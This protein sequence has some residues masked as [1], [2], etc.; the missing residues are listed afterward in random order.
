[1]D[2]RNQ[3]ERQLRSKIT[4]LPK[5]S[6]LIRKVNMNIQ[7]H[8]EKQKHQKTVSQTD[9]F[10]LSKTAAL[11]CL[12][13]Y[14]QAQIIF[15]GQSKAEKLKW[16][17]LNAEQ[18][19][20][21]P[22][23]LFAVILESLPFNGC[24]LDFDPKSKAHPDG[25]DPKILKQTWVEWE[26]DKYPW[27]QDSPHGKHALF[28]HAPQNITSGSNKA[29]QGIDY[30]AGRNLFML[31]DPALWKNDLR[32][33]RPLPA[34]ALEIIQ[35]NQYQKKPAQPGHG[36]TN[37]LLNSGFGK[38]KNSKNFY[39]IADKAVSIAEDYKKNP[40]KTDRKEAV[41]KLAKSLES[42]L[43]QNNKL[44]DKNQKKLPIEWVYAI[45][46]KE[47]HNW[48][49]PEIMP[50][51]IIIWAGLTGQGKTTSLLN[52]LTLNAIK[53]KLPGTD[54]KGDGRPFLYHGPEN[55]L[56][57]IQKRVIDCGGDLGKTIQFMKIKDFPEMH[58]PREYLH[59]EYIKAIES[60]QFSAVVS[61]PI[62]LLLKDQN[63]HAGE[64]LL[65]L[66]QACQQNETA[67]IGVAHIKKSIN[68]QEII[69]HIRGDSDIVT[70]ARSVIYCREGKEK[71]KKVIVPLKNS[72]TG[73]LDNGF[74]T[75][76]A[77]NDSP[78]LFTHYTDNN[79]AILKE[80][81]KAFSSYT[82]EPEDSPETKN[83][84][85]D[86]LAV[87]QTHGGD[88]KWKNQDFKEWLKDRIKKDLDQKARQRLL[89]KAGL[90]QRAVGRGEWGL[91]KKQ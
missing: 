36:Q 82:D 11:A 78:V 60:K 45:H 54:Q 88:G 55:A 30:G 73:E 83:L 40:G 53:A 14:P 31:Y 21:Q 24:R 74:V 71:N 10:A 75:S 43:S 86:I 29:G 15:R 77:D 17:P 56:K 46:I 38:Y 57:I 72:L 41:G 12:K 68:D 70:L 20:K 3:E 81:A 49:L 76:M 6:S 89:K 63:Q 1:M 2:P 80:H 48:L 61:D 25:G 51:D 13:A 16:T 50:Y 58:I 27:T 37:N 26:L 23:G 59:A 66:A 18:I 35:K 87:F 44:H 42:G 32:D 28:K 19:K 22:P 4:Y 39:Q 90:T 65:P 69:H 91:F 5:L 64:T 85:S 62:Y 33:I 67:F 52:I 9:R 34:G 7:T 8:P 47:K 84:I 79:F